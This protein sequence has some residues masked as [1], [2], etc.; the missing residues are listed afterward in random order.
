[1]SD[2]C[3]SARTADRHCRPGGVAGRDDPAG[4]RVAVLSARGDG[5]PPK[6]A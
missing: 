1:M 6:I 4:A 2:S 5:A 3:E